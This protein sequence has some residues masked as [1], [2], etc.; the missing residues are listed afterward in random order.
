MGQANS[1]ERDESSSKAH[2]AD[3]MVKYGAALLLAFLGFIPLTASA[4]PEMRSGELF[5]TIQGQRGLSELPPKGEGS[6][7]GGSGSGEPP[8]DPEAE[9]NAFFEDEM[10]PLVY[11]TCYLSCH[12]SGGL[13]G[14]SDLVLSGPGSNQIAAN[15]TAFKNFITIFWVFIA[16][17][18]QDFRRRPPRWRGLFNRLVGLPDH[19]DVDRVL[20]LARCHHSLQQGHQLGE[21]QRV[22]Q[23]DP[24]ALPK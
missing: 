22:N 6:P 19:Q 4:D 24:V 9:A 10:H 7:G 16:V 5:D 15:Y 1:V 13:A 21:P 18:N 11:P 20:R 23:G 8:T 12:Q 14:G 17:T 2:S 3:K